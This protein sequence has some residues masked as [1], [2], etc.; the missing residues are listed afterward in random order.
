MDKW[1]YIFIV[2]I[3]VFIVLVA[4]INH[5]ISKGICEKQAR[6]FEHEYTPMG[7]CMV[8]HKGVWL[9]LENIRSFERDE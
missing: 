9:P 4:G 6:S 3:L 1:D 8:E 5:L 7:G 2:G